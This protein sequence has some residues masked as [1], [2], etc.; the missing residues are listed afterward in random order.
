MRIEPS[1]DNLKFFKSEPGIVQFKYHNPYTN[2]EVIRKISLTRADQ[3]KV[4]L[5]TIFGVLLGVIGAPI[6]Y[7]YTFKKLRERQIQEIKDFDPKDEK[8]NQEALQR[9]FGKDFALRNRDSVIRTTLEK[10][11]Q[12]SQLPL[13]W[14]QLNNKCSQVKFYAQVN[15]NSKERYTETVVIRSQSDAPLT[16]EEVQEALKSKLQ[17]LRNKI[18]ASVTT[19]NEEQFQIKSVALLKMPNGTWGYAKGSRDAFKCNFQSGVAFGLNIREAAGHFRRL[20]EEI[21]LPVQQVTDRNLNFI[22]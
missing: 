18:A 22:D 4:A 15:L 5:A 7:F 16:I 6:L 17:A 20:L 12:P 11:L 8:V 14:S 19:L 10:I 13:D 21:N 2:C 1:S 3:I 9:F